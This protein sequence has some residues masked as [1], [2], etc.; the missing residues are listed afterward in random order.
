MGLRVWSRREFF[1]KKIIKKKKTWFDLTPPPPIKTKVKYISK[2]FKNSQNRLLPWKMYIE[3]HIFIHPLIVNF[4]FV[5]LG[6]EDDGTYNFLVCFHYL[7]ILKVKVYVIIRINSAIYI[8]RYIQGHHYKY[9]VELWL[10]EIMTIWNYDHSD[11]WPVGIMTTRIYDKV[12]LWPVGIMIITNF[13]W[14]KS[15]LDP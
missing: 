11:L 10:V 1:S 12:E 6:T 8:N 13:D 2:E 5:A 9:T 7:I 3:T 4:I 15:W 14:L